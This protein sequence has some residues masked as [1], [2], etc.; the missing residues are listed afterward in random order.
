MRPRVG[1]STMLM[2]LQADSASRARPVFSG[3]AY[4]CHD[5]GTQSRRQIFF[6][7][8]ERHEENDGLSG[9]KAKLRDANQLDA[10][11]LIL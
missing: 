3:S 10:N 6:M 8:D 1:A 4:A 5:E 2:K 7:N 9:Q 11:V